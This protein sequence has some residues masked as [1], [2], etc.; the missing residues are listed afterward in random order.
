M[1]E[2]QELL[3]LTS[4]A[5][6]T[7]SNAGFV[8]RGLKEL[9]AGKAPSLTQQEDGTLDA[10]FSDGT[11]TRLPPNCALKDAECS[12]PA[13]GM[14]RH[15]VMLVLTYQHQHA[16]QPQAQEAS[17]PTRWQPGDWLSELEDLP[18]ATQRRAQ[19]LAAQGL[20]IDLSCSPNEVPAAHFPMSDVRFFSRNSLRFARC[21]C[22]EG[23]LCEHVILAVQAFAAA[24]AYQPGFE[25]ITW[26]LQQEA[27]QKTSAADNPFNTEEG[28]ACIEDRKSVV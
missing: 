22:V 1:N 15:R 17:E 4:Q 16:E 12:C 19:A 9:E 11:R 10:L 23:T 3:E 20:I 27:T 13:S 8:K 25:K 2:R 6:I 7:L 21:D 28:Q 5:L 14:C 26:Q 18:A 24:E